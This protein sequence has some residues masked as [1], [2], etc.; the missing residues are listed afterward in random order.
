MEVRSA[1]VRLLA[2]SLTGLLSVATAA[3]LPPVPNGDGKFISLNLQGFVIQDGNDVTITSNPR[4]I[5]PSHHYRFDTRGTVHG[6][7]NFAS[8]IPAKTNLVTA[9]NLVDGSGS[10][11]RGAVFESVFG[12]TYPLVNKQVNGSL[13]PISVSGR[14]ESGVVNGIATFSLKEFSLT[15]FG[16]HNTA[17]TIVF[18]NVFLIGESADI[19]KSDFDFDANSDL[20]LFDP[21]KR[22]VRFGYL[23][24]IKY[25][26]SNA[27]KSVLPALNGKALPS[28]FNHAGVADFDLDGNVDLLLYNPKS[29]ATKIILLNLDKLKGSSV[30]TS[31]IEGPTI[32]AGFVLGGTGDSNLDG[33][34]DLFAYNPTT[35]Q[36]QWILLQAGGAF[37]TGDQT[38]S[39]VAGPALPA[40]FAV[41]GLSDFNDDGNIDLL[42][43]NPKSRAVKALYLG[44]LNTVVD[45][46]TLAKGWT[47][48]GS[49]GFDNN[50]SLDLVIYNDK[51]NEAAFHVA[52]G[53]TFDTI[54][55]KAGGK[56]PLVK[57]LKLV[58]PR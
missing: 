33:T 52:K 35:L 14:L 55:K 10:A 9:L 42:L 43:Y 30:A 26:K 56:L 39:T 29:R 11:L 32:P 19:V 37:F 48:I 2:L 17:D 8:V 23:Q 3:A 38:A 28:G 5:G 40:K 47:L 25:L 18:D 58:G 31:T 27:K 41:Y 1:L 44:G 16:F 34:Y 22:V 6:T 46:P 53:A 36:S 20:I 4:T 12:D 54:S 24:G 13:G 21:K 57:G 7:G 45:G 49:S 15:I 51:T 50:R